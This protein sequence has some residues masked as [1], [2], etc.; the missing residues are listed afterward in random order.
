ML[1][2]RL[3]QKHCTDVFSTLGGVEGGAQ[4]FEQKREQLA[5]FSIATCLQNSNSIEGVPCPR[6]YRQYVVKAATSP[7][8]GRSKIQKLGA[9]LAV[10]L[11]EFAVP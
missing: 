2:T 3:P 7:S 6:K 11:V 5:C 8:H 1:P 4:F 10:T 9:C